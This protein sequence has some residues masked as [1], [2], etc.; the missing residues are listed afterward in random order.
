MQLFIE[1]P[2]G[3]GSTLSRKEDMNQAQRWIRRVALTIDTSSGVGKLPNGL[4]TIIRRH[5]P[6]ADV[7]A[8]DPR[9]FVGLQRL[10]MMQHSGGLTLFNFT[11]V[12]SEPANNLRGWKAC[13]RQLEEWVRKNSAALLLS[14]GSPHFVTIAGTLFAAHTAEE[15]ACMMEEVLVLF[16]TPGVDRSDFFNYKVID[17]VTKTLPDGKEVEQ[18]AQDFFWTT[19]FRTPTRAL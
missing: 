19:N 4:Q 1:L 5:T 3:K 17:A 14:P 11:F 6:L 7:P 16:G 9:N 12:V 2:F 8:D 15:M 18:S 10:E 13:Q